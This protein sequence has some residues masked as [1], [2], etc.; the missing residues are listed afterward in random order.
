MKG[1]Y[2]CPACCSLVTRRSGTN[3][4]LAGQLTLVRRANVLDARALHH[5]RLVVVAHEGWNALREQVRREAL[6]CLEGL[7][8]IRSQL[9]PDNQ[10]PLRLSLCNAMRESS[11]KEHFHCP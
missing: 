9:Q 7:I 10:D 8:D 6:S 2:A 4:F 5:V 1:I 3:D 11:I